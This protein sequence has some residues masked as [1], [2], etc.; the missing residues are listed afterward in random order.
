MSKI[1]ERHFH[2]D[3]RLIIQE[4]HDFNPILDRA[5]Q[6]RSAGIDGFGSDS[7]MVGIIPMHMWTMWAR[8]WGVDPQDNAAMEEVVDRELADPDNAHFRVWGGRL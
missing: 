3:G 7:K 4:T 1:A 5:A 6:L 8:K 2:D